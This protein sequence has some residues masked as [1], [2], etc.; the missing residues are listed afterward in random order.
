MPSGF[1]HTRRAGPTSYEASLRRPLMPSGF[2]HCT[3]SL[4]RTSGSSET[5]PY[6]FGL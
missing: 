6:A 1:Q 4:Q 3:S 2:E 5:A